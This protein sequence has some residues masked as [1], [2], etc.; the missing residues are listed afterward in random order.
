MNPPIG[1]FRPGCPG[2]AI[3]SAVAVRPPAM[4]AHT[5]TGIRPR[6]VRMLHPLGPSRSRAPACA[7]VR[8]VSRSVRESE[9]G[10]DP[11]QLCDGGVQL[12]IADIRGRAEAQDVAARVGKNCLL[13]QGS[14]QPHR[15]R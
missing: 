7:R 2:L 5:P 15:V 12:V 11:T 14:Y 4:V 3:S 6:I 13:A 8:V 10:D 1:A 9:C